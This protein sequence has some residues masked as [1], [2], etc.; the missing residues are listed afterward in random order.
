MRSEKSASLNSTSYLS[1][2]KIDGF[3]EPPDFQ[4]RRK[5][6]QASVSTRGVM[7]QHISQFCIDLLPKWCQAG[8][9]KLLIAARYR[10][11][12]IHHL[13]RLI[14]LFRDMCQHKLMRKTIHNPISKFGIVV[15]QASAG[16]QGRRN[17]RKLRKGFLHNAL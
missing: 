11:H 6:R 9:T 13:L 2:N 1:N 3:N 10:L 16:L 12:W 15:C 17:L 5:N 14:I 7:I 8:N 4:K